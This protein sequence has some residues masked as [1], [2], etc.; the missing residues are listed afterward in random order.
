[1]MVTIA[2]SLAVLPVT[3]IIWS[4]ISLSANISKARAIG[5]PVLIRY[6]TPSNPLWMAFG[7]D[8][9]RLA[10]RLG[11]ASE[12]FDRFYL[13]GWDANE[14]H[15]VHAEFGDA[16][17]LVSPG[18]NW[19]YVVDPKAAWHIL[20]HSRDFGRNTKALAVLDVYGK[21]LSTAEGH[22]WQK[23]R[24]VTAAT[25]TEK[26]NELVWQSSLSQGHGMLQY[27]LERASQ[28]VHSI[29]DDSKTFTLN[30][31]AA[32]LFTKPYPFEGQEE[33]KKRHASIEDRPD[34]SHQY[35]DSLSK[36]LRG[37]I[38]IAIFGEETLQKSVWMPRSW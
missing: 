20:K 29:A 34:D 21:N 17:T 9:V 33:L 36:I 13:F 18:G 24:K 16:F 37:I 27:W 38:L 12:N 4:A 6:V 5:L 11:I 19:I 32:A 7:S 8:I 2:L 23:H 35:R 25:F 15:R 1:M 26:N 31:L 30:V 3:L 22:E 10:R 28:P 14:R